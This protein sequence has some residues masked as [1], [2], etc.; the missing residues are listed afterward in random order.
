MAYQNAVQVTIDDSTNFTA[1]FYTTGA[2]IVTQSTSA[3]SSNYINSTGHGLVD[4]DVIQIIDASTTTGIT[5]LTDY[6]VVASDANKFKL[7][8]SFA[9]LPIA[10]S[11]GTPSFM[12]IN[13]Y[14]VAGSPNVQGIV[15]S[16]TGVTTQS[17]NVLPS[18]FPDAD[19]T[20]G[21]PIDVPAGASVYLPIAIK[22]VY[23]TGTGLDI[24]VTAF[25]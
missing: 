11:G 19:N 25:F 17:A 4:N 5:K 24:S 15:V 12:Q 2:N 1:S 21:I 16:N 22:R 7:A 14:I 3:V 20:Y 18:A 8:T 23:Q 9:G 10:I 13:H 6:Y